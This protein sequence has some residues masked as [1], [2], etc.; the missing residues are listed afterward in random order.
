MELTPWPA[1]CWEAVSAS[2]SC[3]D[4]VVGQAAVTASKKDNVV[5]FEATVPEP[6]VELLRVYVVRTK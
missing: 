2:V 1:A 3:R 6:S 4:A 5:T